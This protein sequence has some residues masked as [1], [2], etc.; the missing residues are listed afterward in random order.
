[1]LI[2]RSELS[3]LTNAEQ[4]PSGHPHSAKIHDEPV[5]Q[6]CKDISQ[7]SIPRQK[8]SDTLIQESPHVDENST[9]FAENKKTT[10]LD[11]PKGTNDADLDEGLNTGG[12]V[13]ISI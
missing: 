10:N 9:S 4:H 6:R 13:F 11:N 2:I 12:W 5:V 1:M 8:N 3:E 7:K